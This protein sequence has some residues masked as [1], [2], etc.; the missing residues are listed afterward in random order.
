[1][2]SQMTLLALGVKCGR[3]SGGD[4]AGVVEE[5]VLIA[6]GDQPATNV[7][8]LHKLLLQLPVGVPTTLTLLRGERKLE[9]MVLPGDYPDP[10][11][12]A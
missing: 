11:S 10:V 9:R 1:M 5:D 6:L 12:R 7:D 8:D 2:N 3:P 4:Q